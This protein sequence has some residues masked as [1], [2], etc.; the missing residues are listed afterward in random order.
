[1]TKGLNF[2]S[3]EEQMPASVNRQPTGSLGE[4]IGPQWQLA[5]V[6]VPHEGPLQS[7]LRVLSW[8][9][10]FCIWPTPPSYHLSTC[11]PWTWKHLPET[12]LSKGRTFS[13]EEPTSRGICWPLRKCVLSYTLASTRVTCFLE[14]W[15]LL[16]IW[17]LKECPLQQNQLLEMQISGSYWD[18]QHQ[19]IL[20]EN[21]QTYVPVLLNKT[22]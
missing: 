14:I 22:Y 4:L 21:L 19:H 10:T 5:L 9:P 3:W 16:D 11:L 6:S 15:H 12:L 17:T 7:R 20:G 8:N 13:W 1:M 2:L 18:I